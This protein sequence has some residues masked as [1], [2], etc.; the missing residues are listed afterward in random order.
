MEIKFTDEDH[1]KIEEWVKKYHEE[2]TG[3]K[4][5]FGN[6]M[7]TGMPTNFGWSYKAVCTICKK[8]E[9]SLTIPLD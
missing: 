6:L 8:N 7:Y 2:C 5:H 1:K 3:P 4:Y 9:L